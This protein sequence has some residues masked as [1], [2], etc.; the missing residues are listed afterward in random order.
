M[1]YLDADALNGGTIASPAG[2]TITEPSGTCFRPIAE[3]T[4]R[5]REVL[6]LTA[7]G[8]R[9]KQ[10]AYRL[11]LS[12]RTIEKH[13]QDIMRRLGF[14]STLE[15][16]RWYLEAEAGNRVPSIAHDPWQECRA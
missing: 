5:Q 11:G 14:R 10:V 6:M 16:L 7:S 13:K 15:L 2:V 3:L 12:T 4:A 1:T 8:L 9:A